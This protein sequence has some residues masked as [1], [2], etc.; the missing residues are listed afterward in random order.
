MRERLKNL[1]ALLENDS[2]EQLTH[3]FLAL[4]HHY[5]RFNALMVA[6]FNASEGRL[7][8]IRLREQNSHAAIKLDADIEDVNHPLIRVLRNG[9]PEVWSSLNRGVRIEDESFRGFIQELPNG[10]GL[11]ALPL[12]DFHGR[13]CGV[14]AVFAEQIERFADTRGMFAIYCQVFQHRLNKLQEMDYLRSQLSQIR[15]VFKTR[16]KQMDELLVSLSTSDVATSTELS[17]DYSKIDDLPSAVEAFETAVLM[18]RQRLYG[19]DKNRIADSLG[20]SQRTLAY[21]LAKYRCWL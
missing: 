20:I 14:I 7:D 21:K 12:F 13:A 6:M 1:L 19:K 17:R 4:N 2:V 15:A 3:D 11:Y 8:C 18:Q 16:E 5:K 10:C 9:S